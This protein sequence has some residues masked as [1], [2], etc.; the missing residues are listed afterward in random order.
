MTNKNNNIVNLPNLDPFFENGNLISKKYKDIF[1]SNLN[2]FEESIFVFFKSINLEHHLEKNENIVIAETGFGTGLN[3]LSL[4]YLKNKINTKSCVQYISFENYPLEEKIVERAHK[5]FKN[6]STFSNLLISKWPRRWPG[7]HNFDFENLNIKVQIC[8]G[9]IEKTIEKCS[10]NAD[11]W[12]LDGFSPSKNTK[13]WSDIVFKNI[14]RLSSNNSKLATFT[15]SRKI[16]DYLQKNGFE[17]IKKKGFHNKREMIT[18]SL[19]KNNFSLN[20]NYNKIIIIGGGIAGASVAHQ[21]S[22]D[23]IDHYLI[24]RNDIASGASGNLAGIVSPFLTVNDTLSSRL[25]VSCLSQTRN[26]LEKE[27]LI[28]SEGVINLDFPERLRVRNI[29]LSKIDFPNDLGE[30]FDSK[31]VNSISG[32]KCDYGG[33]FFKTGCLINPKKYCEILLKQSLVKKFSNVLKIRG[34][35]GDW[36]ITDNNGKKYFGDYIV[37]C[38]GPEIVNLLKELKIKINELQRTAGQITYLEGRNIFD[39]LRVSLNYGG[40]ITT[41]IDG[42][43]ILGASFD[44]NIDNNVTFA[45]HD[46]NLNLMPKNFVSFDID[47]NKL[48]GRTSIRLATSDR[49][50]LAGEIFPGVSILSALGSRGLTNSLLLGKLVVSNISGNP[51][52]LDDDIKKLVN[53]KRI[54]K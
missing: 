22:K 38:S 4:M 32:I 20:K 3:L 41:Q 42:K 5:K 50:P 39:N 12:F 28:I 36:E 26:I 34:R 8:Y 37:L 27:N 44:H 40:Y 47:K 51:M 14:A 9:D 21:L 33:F 7:I 23:K 16:Y 11:F 1:F 45:R 31:K 24:E 10:F 43:N 13:M 19:K 25:S 6:L 54:I 49:M 15:S 52:I 46:Y 18:A 35:D 17:V 48:K 30:Y 29:K 53:P 2:G